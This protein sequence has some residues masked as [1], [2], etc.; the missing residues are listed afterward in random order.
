MLGRFLE[1][2][3]HT[4]DIRQSVEFYERL[5]FSQALT[6]DALIHPYG[7]LTDGVLFLGLHQR[8]FFTPTLSFVQPD[9]AQ[10]TTALEK[11]GIEIESR[12][13]DSESFN[14]I[15][16]LDPNSVQISLLEARTFSPPPRETHEYSACG[17]F[18]SFSAPC[19]DL[20]LTQ[21]FWESLGF[22][23]LEE[24]DAPYPRLRLVKDQL[25][26][27]FHARRQLNQWCLL[28][29]QKDISKHHSTAA[30]P[31][32]LKAASHVA[33]TSPDE[34]LLLIAQQL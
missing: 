14:E 4:A 22:T 34:L 20:S 6:N 18:V 8:Q 3:I 21:Q 11:R 2:S 29:Q 30:V 12:R 26:L 31:F 19:N 16:L 32:G 33:F 24:T 10:H 27:D 1:L 23:T 7:V 28:F 17:R 5:G 9:V 25:R 15:T 13:I